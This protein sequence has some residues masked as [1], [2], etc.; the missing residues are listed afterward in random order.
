MYKR[1]VQDELSKGL[2]S[3]L[4]KLRRGLE[5]HHEDLERH[6]K[7]MDSMKP[8]HLKMIKQNIMLLDEY[9]K[10]KSQ[11]AINRTM[12]DKLR[13]IVGWEDFGE[14]CSPNAMLFVNN[15]TVTKVIK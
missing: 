1:N 11:V 7:S 6:K 13:C 15:T 9:N 8:V 10:L 2:K 4:F 12:N 5:I 3:D 14:S